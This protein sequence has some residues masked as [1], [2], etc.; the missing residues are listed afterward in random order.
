M[1]GYSVLNLSLSAHYLGLGLKYK[2]RKE[3]ASCCL[4]VI[5]FGSRNEIQL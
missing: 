4:V 3:Y 1:Y 2:F 5:R